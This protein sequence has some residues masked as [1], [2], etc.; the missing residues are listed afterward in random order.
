MATETMTEQPQ[1]EVLEEQALARLRE[2]DPQ[3]QHGVLQRVLTAF[4]ASLLRAAEQLAELPAA[5][6]EAMLHTLLRT[7]HTLKSSSASVGAAHLARTC[8]GVEQRLRALELVPA[9]AAGRPSQLRAQL[10]REAEAVALALAPAQ[11]A[12]RAMLRA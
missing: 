8:A 6:D 3:G 7:T 5:S 10:Q 4:D 12:V 11:Q 1:P 9:G 2:L